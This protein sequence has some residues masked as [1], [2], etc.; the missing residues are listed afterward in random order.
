MLFQLHRCLFLTVI[1]LMVI[2]MACN[3]VL[4][5]ISWL[6]ISAVLPSK[7]VP[8]PMKRSQVINIHLFHISFEVHFGLNM[9]N[10]YN[11]KSHFMA[12]RKEVHFAMQYHTICS[13]F[14]LCIGSSRLLQ[15]VAQLPSCHRIS[16]G[17]H[18]CPPRRCFFWR[19]SKSFHSVVRPA[20]VR[21]SYAVPKVIAAS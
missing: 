5:E 13:S 15:R 12:E 3:G 9:Y 2:I 7:L 20:I 8:H 1:C 6:K 10:P 16:S 19:K 4:G 21:P 11:L 18:Q 14:W 17:A